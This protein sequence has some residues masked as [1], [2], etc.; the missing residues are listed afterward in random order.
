MTFS[1][2]SYVQCIDF[3][4]RSLYISLGGKRNRLFIKNPLE[5]KIYAKMFYYILEASWLKMFLCQVIVDRLSQKYKNPMTGSK[6]W[7]RRGWFK[8]HV[9]TP[10]CTTASR[11]GFLYFVING[12][13]W[14]DKEPLFGV[15]IKYWKD[16]LPFEIIL[17][18]MNWTGWNVHTTISTF[19]SRIESF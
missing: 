1:L 10:F 14:P 18:S 6:W 9:E 5:S 15:M 11:I 12:R 8:V 2:L 19:D 16:F 3:H 4:F 13:Q 7:S 17:I